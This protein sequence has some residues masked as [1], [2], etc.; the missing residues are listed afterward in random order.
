VAHTECLSQALA[1]AVTRCLACCSKAGAPRPLSDV[2]VLDFSHVIASPVVGR[3]LAEH[4][5][6]VIK[7]VTQKRPRRAL[8]DEE[9]NQGKLTLEVLRLS[10]GSAAVSRA[11][12]PLVCVSVVSCVWCL[13]WC[14]CGVSSRLCR[15]LSHVSSRASLI[16]SDHEP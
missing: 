16:V 1:V 9:A 12:V 14:S 7:L 15:V 2:L 11:A 4:G 13:T 3:T 8:F 5:A 10:I 6:T